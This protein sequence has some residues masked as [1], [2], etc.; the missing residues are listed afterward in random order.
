MRMKRLIYG[1]AALATAMS[2]Y[3][4]HGQSG[5]K[6]VLYVS[7]DKAS[8]TPIMPGASRATIWGDPDKGAHGTYTKFVAGYDAGVHTHTSDLRIVVIKG[9]YL[10][11][12]GGTGGK[13]T[14]VGAGDFLFVPGGE[15]HWSGGDPKD[16]AL[17]YEEGT[18]K[19]DL[20]PVK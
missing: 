13:E 8:F 9:A 19:F 1:L 18:G 15:R 7:P 11:K 20:N 4:V 12:A 2:A 16:G 6:E 5:K 14:R 3:A 10:Y 17:F